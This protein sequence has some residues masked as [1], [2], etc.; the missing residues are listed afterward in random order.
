MT[1]YNELNLITVSQFKTDGKPNPSV[2][3]PPRGNSLPAS[4]LSENRRPHRSI[5][6]ESGSASD[7]ISSMKRSW[8][9]KRDTHENVARPL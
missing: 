9:T 5:G 2:H 7:P 3:I 4:N 8:K 1:I 6:S